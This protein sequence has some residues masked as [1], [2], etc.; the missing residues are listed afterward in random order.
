MYKTDNCTLTSIAVL[1]GFNLITFCTFT[2]FLITNSLQPI[3]QTKAS[4]V[5]SKRVNIEGYVVTELTSTPYEHC[6]KDFRPLFQNIT[7]GD[8]LEHCSKKTENSTNFGIIQNTPEDNTDDSLCKKGYTHISGSPEIKL[9]RLESELICAKFVKMNYETS[10]TEDCPVGMHSCGKLTENYFCINDEEKCPI[11]DFQIYPNPLLKEFPDKWKYQRVLLKEN[12]KIFLYYTKNKKDGNILTNDWIL[13]NPKGVCLNPNEIVTSNEVWQYWGRTYVKRCLSVIDNLDYDKD[14]QLKYKTTWK[15]ILKNNKFDFNAE[16]K[17]LDIRLDQIEDW[18]I[19]IFHKSK[20]F[21]N[22][23]CKDYKSTYDETF[24]K[25][26]SAVNYEI[27]FILVTISVV[28]NSCA[29]ILLFVQLLIGCLLKNGKLVRNYTI[30]WKMLVKSLSSVALS[31][32]IMITLLIASLV[33]I[34]QNN[35]HIYQEAKREGKQCVDSNMTLFIDFFI[36]NDNIISDIVILTLSLSIISCF[37]FIIFFLIIIK[38]FDG[39]SDLKIISKT[40]NVK[41]KIQSANSNSAEDFNKISKTT[42]STKSKYSQKSR[43]ETYNHMKSIMFNGGE[44]NSIENNTWST[45]QMSGIKN[46]LSKMPKPPKEEPKLENYVFIDEND[47]PFDDDKEG[48]NS[49]IAELEM[50]FSQFLKKEDQKKS[51]VKFKSNSLSD[52]SKSQEFKYLQNNESETFD[53]SR[54]SSGE[55][56]S[57]SFGIIKICP[58]LLKKKRSNKKFIESNVDSGTNESFTSNN[59]SINKINVNFLK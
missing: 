32:F 12:P 29:I 1:L 18:D 17:E 41:S 37:T 44:Y 10:T 38:N 16:K 30:N 27:I 26:G 24:D 49:D 55:N 39:N 22:K 3:Y 50:G 56:Q 6:P 58:E 4:I 45:F 54:Y 33:L 35:N 53:V 5:S 20:I 46:N 2:I 57:Q 47:D 11:N 52:I 8:I 21:F 36:N 42:S 51:I 13:G 40:N 34:K 25:F 31:N 7:T 28:L 19:G 14:Y 9:E 59:T 23:E 15:T 43:D 48:S